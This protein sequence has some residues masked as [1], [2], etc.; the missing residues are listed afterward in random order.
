VLKAYESGIPPN[1]MATLYWG[2]PVILI[3]AIVTIAV[4]FFGKYI[5]YLVPD[6]NL[7]QSR[8]KGHPNPE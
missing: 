8:L 2:L 5:K 3:L 6:S 4:L 1:Q 7:I